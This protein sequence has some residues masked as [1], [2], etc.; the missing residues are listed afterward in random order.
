MR[1]LICVPILLRL[2]P[3]WHASTVCEPLPPSPDALP[4]SLPTSLPPSP[5]LCPSPCWQ[6]GEHGASSAQHDVLVQL[7]SFVM[8]VVAV[9]VM[10]VV[11]GISSR[12]AGR[13]KVKKAGGQERIRVM[14]ACAHISGLKRQKQ[15]PPSI[16]EEASRAQQSSVL[17]SLAPHQQFD[18]LHCA[19]HTG[20]TA[21]RAHGDAGSTG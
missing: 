10:L 21:A 13:Q 9:V 11:V 3:L 5:P 6:S 15:G 14:Q 18:A 7:S 4:P 17:H 8:T 2:L 12:Q 1:S 16:H 19:S 20:P